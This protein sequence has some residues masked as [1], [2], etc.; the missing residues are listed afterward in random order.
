MS[1]LKFTLS[2]LVSA[3][4]SADWS[5]NP[6]ISHLYAA[7]SFSK[8]EDN[9]LVEMIPAKFSL[10]R[11]G[12]NVPT[13]KPDPELPSAMP[14][15]K[16][17]ALRGLG[18]LPAMLLE[19]GGMAYRAT[20]YTRPA[21][22]SIKSALEFGRLPVLEI[23]GL[24][25]SQSNTIV[26][27][28]A[29]RAK[30]SGADSS[31]RVR[32]DSL[33]ETFRDLYVSHGTWG[34]AFDVDAL[35]EGAAEGEQLLHFRDTSNK[36]DFSP[37]QKAAAA[38]KTFEDLLA[39]SASGYLVGSNLTYVDL[40]LWQ[41][42]HEVG[43]EDRLGAGWADRL[44]MPHLGRFVSNVYHQN[45]CVSGFVSS[46]RRMP[47]IKKVEKDYVYLA[48]SQ[49]IPVPVVPKLASSPIYSDTREL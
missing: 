42:L 8:A 11:F 1:A 26:R 35:R 13:L 31:E 5:S 14:H 20:Y 18:D 41:K 38:L 24:E 19:C 15:L 9:V 43:Q 16:Y 28:L 46:G 36:G 25:I 32:V 37:F 4:A 49:L 6:D 10:N 48:D 39:G 23:A 47:R 30:L 40:A 3:A 22:A 33:Y 21:F 44:G 17:M 2:L 34:N 12:S 7:G 29:D 27:Y 45:Q